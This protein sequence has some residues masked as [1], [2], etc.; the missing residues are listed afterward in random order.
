MIARAGTPVAKLVP[1]TSRPRR[2]P[3]IWADRWQT[4][5]EWD[6]AEL[7]EQ[8]ADEFESSEIFP[9]DTTGER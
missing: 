7:N 2:V 3:G 1:L 6:S 8:I 4:G 5:Q 9:P